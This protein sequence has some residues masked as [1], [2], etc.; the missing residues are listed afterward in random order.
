MYVYE[1]MTYF[2]KQ[3]KE[4][5]IILSIDK[6]ADLKSSSSKHRAQSERDTGK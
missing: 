5:V 4:R 3:E 1:S 2:L 6:L